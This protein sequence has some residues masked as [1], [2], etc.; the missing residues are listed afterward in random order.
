MIDQARDDAGLIANFVKMTL[1]LAD[2]GR[3]NL[4]DERQYRRVHSICGQQCGAGIEQ[5]W[6]WYDRVG[7]W[8]ACRQRRT[9][10]HIGCALFMPGMDDA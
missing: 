6:A 7:L 1:T 4:S 8:S 10:G 3:G 5:T 2:R 9:Q